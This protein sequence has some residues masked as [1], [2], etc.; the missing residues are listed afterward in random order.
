MAN[1]L[2]H[3]EQVTILVLTISVFEFVAAMSSSR[4]DDVTQLVSYRY[5]R[6][7]FG[8]RY[9]TKGDLIGMIAWLPQGPE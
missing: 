6:Y 2:C 4:I 9:T 1:N 5:Y 3:L 8:N 7:V